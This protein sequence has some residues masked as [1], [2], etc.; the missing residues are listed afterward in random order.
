MPGDPTPVERRK[1]PRH[2]GPRQ[3]AP[4]GASTPR[5]GSRS[6]RRPVAEDVSPW[7]A[8][9]RASTLPVVKGA[10]PPGRGDRR[11][12]QDP[13]RGPEHL[14]RHGRPAAAQPPLPRRRRARAAAPG[15]RATPEARAVQGP[16]ETERRRQR[17]VPLR[18]PVRVQGRDANGTGWEEMSTCEDA[19][20]GGAALLVSHPVRPGQV[21]HLS[22][23]L[24][25]RF[26]QYD[27]HRLV[28]PDL[29]PRPAHPGLGERAAGGRAVPRPA[30]AAGGRVA[31]RGPLLHAGRARGADGAGPAA[32]LRLRLEAE[33]APGGVRAGRGRRGRARWSRRRLLV[34]TAR[35]P[36]VPGSDRGGG[37]E[38][39][40]T[41]RSRAEVDAT[42]RSGPT[43]SPRVSLRFLDEPVPER[44][45]PRDDAR[46]RGA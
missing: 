44:L 32:T 43:G 20:V 36:V 9:V 37:G 40:S 45:L 12:L 3:P 34:R 26:R 30:P 46:P 6:R 33:H 5:A 41:F 35:L 15:G 11:R 39:R 38:G 31:P 4:R 42:S 24:P 25:R 7:G 14:D 1:F 8:Q 13:R 16:P 28:V 21:L 18:L 2:A 29:R 27:V 17:R 19:S 23:P 10:D 22:V